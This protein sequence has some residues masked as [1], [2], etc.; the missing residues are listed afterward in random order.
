M[1]NS[2]LI[3]TLGKVII[4]AA[5]ADGKIAHDEIVSLKDLMFL[6]PDLTRL[7]WAELD[8]YIETPVSAEERERLIDE[9]RRQVRSGKDRQFALETLQAM[10]SADGEITDSEQAVMDDVQEQLEGGMNII[11]GFRRLVGG[12]IDERKERLKSAP[13]RSEFYDDFI[14]N[15]VY[16]EVQ[17]RLQLGEADLDI[18]DDQLRKLSF[19]GGLMAQ[20]ARV[21]AGINE[22]ELQAIAQALETHWQM[23]R[24]QAVFVAQVATSELAENL[25]YMRTAREFYALCT[26]DELDDFLDVLFEVA[27]S[28]GMATYA[29]IEEI[30]AISRTLHFSHEQFINAKIKIPKDKRET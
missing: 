15:K 24:V 30:R 26:Q 29:E 1:A 13:N 3:M 18:P 28:D 4:A 21:H 2:D 23:P 20:I 6:L 22:D 11:G 12:S 5:W 7:Q 14:K 27:A 9:L 17:R 8:M 16:Y 10:I 25:D 19:A